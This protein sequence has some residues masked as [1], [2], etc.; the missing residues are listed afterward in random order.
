[1]DMSMSIENWYANLRS[2][3]E[4]LPYFNECLNVNDKMSIRENCTWKLH[5]Q[6]TYK[7]VKYRTT[8]TGIGDRSRFWLSCLGSLVLLLQ[9]R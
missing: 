6:K 2:I 1:M 9:K 3:N 4:Y 5:S 8:F 7:T